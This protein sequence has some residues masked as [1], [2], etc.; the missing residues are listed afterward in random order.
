MIDIDVTWVGQETQS[1]CWYAALKMVVR[2]RRGADAVVAGHPTALQAGIDREKYRASIDTMDITEYAK[3]QLRKENP[4]RGLDDNEL[5]GLVDMNGLAAVVLPQWNE[6]T[7]EGAWT[8]GTLE[9]E[10]REHGPLWCSVAF[11]GLSTA[12]VIV[13]KGIDDK[14]NVIYLD[15]QI[16]GNLT[17]TMAKFNDC[18]QWG[19]YCMLYVPAVT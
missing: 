19:K 2:H 1:Q 8:D 6:A 10:L 7:Q 16:A 4:L 12:H 9:A 13:V 3:K 18:L 14:G 5:P 11:P 17:W 15:P